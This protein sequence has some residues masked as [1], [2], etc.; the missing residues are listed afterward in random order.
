MSERDVM[1]SRRMMIG[2]GVTAGAVLLGPSTWGAQGTKPDTGQKA[3]QTAAGE[4]QEPNMTATEA[5]MRQHAVVSRL[6]LIYDNASMPEAGA[7]TT[8]AAASTTRPSA[9]VLASTAQLLRANVDDNHAQMEEQFVFPMFQKANKMTDLVAT[10]RE[11][12]VAARKLTDS[13][14]RATEK[15]ESSNAEALSAD[16]KAYVRMIQAHTAYE[17]T[18]LY[19]QIHTVMSPKG[20]EQ[21]L[22]RIQDADNKALGAGGFAGLL[23][24]ITDLERSA[25]ITSLAQF[26]PKVTG[27]QTAMANPPR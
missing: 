15:G 23:A 5:L 1:Y 19:P 6:L 22:T 25:G 4:S 27:G 11:Q 24:K 3:G 20:F 10:L 2:A 14:L 18:Q 13:I 9:K 16:L 7:T 26:T 17:E 21:L 8:A 12:H